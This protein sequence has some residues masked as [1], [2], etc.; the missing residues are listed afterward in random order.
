M[1]KDYLRKKIR[2]EKRK[3]SFEELKDLSR[4]IINKLLLH[5]KVVKTKRILMYFPLKDEVD[6]LG[7]ILSLKQ[8]GKEVFL[9]R[10]KENGRMELAKFEGLDNL[11]EG[12]FGIM[13]P[14]AKTLEDLGEIELAVIPGMAFDTNGNRLGRGKGYY[15]H[16]LKNMKKTYKIG[17]CFHFQ[18]LP[19]IPHDF[20]DEKVDEVL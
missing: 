8:K 1:N 15:D 3:F 4:P 12:A 11:I 9:P 5:P 2:L 6:T 7:A 10:I 20:Y 19:L 18:K 17:L 16:L 13:E 14:T